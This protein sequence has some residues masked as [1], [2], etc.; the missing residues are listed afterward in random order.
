MNAPIGT[1]ILRP[2]AMDALAAES[3]ARSHGRSYFNTSRCERLP[4]GR[5]RVPLDS[6]AA[7]RLRVLRR[8]GESYSRLIMRLVRETN[9]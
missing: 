1:I 8:K 4:D 9:P 5:W 7:K 3:A 2:E 6:D